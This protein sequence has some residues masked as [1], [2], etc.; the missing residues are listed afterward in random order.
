M[1][2]AIFRKKILLT[3]KQIEKLEKNMKNNRFSKDESKNINI[4]FF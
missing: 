3:F 2:K 4:N 1:A